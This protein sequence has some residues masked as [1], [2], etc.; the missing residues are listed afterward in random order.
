VSTLD[1][2]IGNVLS[3]LR[4]AG[5]KD[6]TRIVYTSDHGDNVGARG[7][8]GKSTFYEESAGVP[9]IIAGAEVERGRLVAT[10]VSHIDCAPSILEAVGAPPRVGG[11]SLPG[12]SLFAIANGATPV[13]PVVSEY[14]AIGSTAGTYMLRFGRY[15]YCHYVGSRP[16]L[17][18]LEADPEE[19]VGLAPDPRH[20]PALA[21]GWHR[22]RAVLDPE[23]VD[24]RAKARQAD[25]LARFGGREAALAR[26]DLGFTPA[27]GTPA[28]MN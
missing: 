13:R 10:P 18:D 25:L 21:E 26:G 12:A 8:W 11:R 5:L 20:A 1:E 24:A 14:H 15:K 6:S 28:E 9:L 16:Q 2:N 7:L 27:P 22:L 19:L 23:G 17:F 4:G 3:A